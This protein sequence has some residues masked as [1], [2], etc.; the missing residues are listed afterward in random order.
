MILGA[1]T[2]KFGNFALQIDDEDSRHFDGPLI[3]KQSQASLMD[4]ASFDSWL[5]FDDWH[6]SIPPEFPESFRLL[7]SYYSGGSLGERILLLT[8]SN[9]LTV[10]IETWSY[11]FE[12][13]SWSMIEN[14]LRGPLTGLLTSSIVVTVCQSYVLH[15]IGRGTT[16]SSVWIFDGESETW[17]E[18]TLE[19]NRAPLITLLE[20]ASYV[21]M[22]NKTASN[23]TSCE[24]SYV[25]VGFSAQRNTVWKLSCNG[26]E[27]KM[28]SWSRI[29]ARGDASL[30]LF[31]F[32]GRAYPR[33]AVCST[34]VAGKDG[35][36]LLMA[37][38]GL[39]RYDM[40]LNQW[41]CL[42]SSVRAWQSSI[43][44][45]N[46]EDKQY[47]LIDRWDF[48]IRIR[49]YSLERK[50][51]SLLEPEPFSAKKFPHYDDKIHHVAINDGFDF[52]LFEGVSKS[53]RQFLWRLDVSLD[54]W[55]LNQIEGA[56]LPSVDIAGCLAADC[57]NDTLYVLV[58][59]SSFDELPTLQLW[60][61]HLNR[62]K[63]TLLERSTE[64][65]PFAL[66]LSAAQTTIYNDSIYLVFVPYQEGLKPADR[67]CQYAWWKIGYNFKNHFNSRMFGDDCEDGINRW[68]KGRIHYCV[69]KI[70]TSTFTVYASGKDALLKKKFSDLWFITLKSESLHWRH[71]QWEHNSQENDDWARHLPTSQYKC[72]V[73]DSSL[74]I[75]GGLDERKNC[76]VRDV[77]NFSLLINNWTHVFVDDRKSFNQQ[78]CIS[79]VVS[80]GPQLL[81]T[82]RSSNTISGELRKYELWFYV[83]K[84]K[85]WISHSKMVSSDE[86]LVSIWRDRIIFFDKDFSGISYKKLVCPP[87]YSSTDLY[88]HACVSCPVGS[89][90]KG[91]GEKT[92]TSCPHGLTTIGTGGS[93][94]VNCSYCEENYCTYG[95]CFVQL[96][97][98]SPRP[99]CQCRLGFSGSRCQDPRYILIAVSVI[100]SMA[101]VVCG[102]VRL[103]HL[104][105]QKKLRER[106]L[107]QHV[108]ELTGVWQIKGNE[109]SRMELIGAGGYGEVYRATYR[110]MIVAMKILRLP[111]DESILWEFEREIKFMQTVRHPNIVLFLGAGRTQDDSPFIVSEFVER[112]TLRD[113]L[114][115]ESHVLSMS[116]KI[117]FCL[118]V[119]H[120]MNFLH[121]LTPPRVHRDLKS[122]NL[123][124]SRSDIVKVTDFGLGKQLVSDNTRA[125]SSIL[126]VR[127]RS[128]RP[129][130]QSQ[131][132]DNC[133]PLL[134]LRSKDS[135]HALGA[136]RWCAPELM[137][138]AS[139]RRCTTAADV[140]RY[141]QH[142][143]AYI[144]SVHRYMFDCFLFSF[145]IVMWE[146]VTRQLPFSEYRFSY[147]VVQAVRAG[148]RPVLPDD[149][150]ET[151]KSL[152]KDCWKGE[153]AQRPSFCDIEHR[154]EELCKY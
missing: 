10:G 144:S 76:C 113:L 69:A 79:S 6:I 88:Q 50:M 140:Y 59:V 25:V 15:T 147:E 54:E 74:L 87:G 154:L 38:D 28:Y 41:R 66:D 109:I 47:I 75:L 91:D 138:S 153:P 45:Y 101:L 107:V 130:S 92:C 102:I 51:W 85:T 18:R 53:G 3:G 115:D 77:W 7:A 23:S 58:D 17:T 117:K 116:M 68:L 33:K 97:D 125:G 84:T 121:S 141:R 122:D 31:S 142:F 20:S 2:A 8:S 108:E 24:C 99:R 73:V 149:C 13:N 132:S 94:L 89:Y 11:R 137:V 111:T 143:C 21:A 37:S 139:E 55:K 14:S 123:L 105:R 52:Y 57:V 106:N 100:I 46:R 34:V 110:D 148:E 96:E 83:P 64:A 104:W 71:V 19:S 60:G 26:N 118:D 48:E 103:I 152:I 30:N 82:F 5:R 9:S 22:L 39:W 151:L 27:V 136:T 72:I 128:R 119:A 120:G 129:R 127:R 62:M 35:S 29:Q 80:V 124:I 61:L 43:F 135:P 4:N 112:G 133:L 1:F 78:M 49:L 134:P 93:S 44:A 131:T 98:G 42:N 90:A 86:F 63:W 32:Y 126:R 16:N 36:I 12:T 114:D 67:K 81:V 56:K 95:D 150:E 70:N 146:I 40:Y 145:A 65:F